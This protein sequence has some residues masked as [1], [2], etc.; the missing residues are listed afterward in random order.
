[1]KAKKGKLL[2]F[3]APSGAGKTTIVHHLLKQDLDLFFSVSA[4]SREKRY[5]E[6]NKKDYHFIGKTKFKELIANDDFLEWEEVYP[7]QFY[8][9]LKS[10]VNAL[11]K[12]GKHVIFDVDVV[13]ALNI[14]KHYGDRA[15]SV[16]VQPPSLKLLKQRLT[17][18]STESE[19]NLKRR[20]NKA[21][22]ELKAANKFD[23]IL[24]NDTLETALKRAEIIAGEF[25]LR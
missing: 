16:F 18:R 14:K 21:T 23:K 13:G 9:T 22:K 3:S 2:I 15:L 1:M 20:L 17:E 10:D 6:I 8:G 11:I 12:E 4:C 19:E 5:N 25:L 24:V 7:D